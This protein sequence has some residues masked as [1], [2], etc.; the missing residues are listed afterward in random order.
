MSLRLS[1][2]E[3][4]VNGAEADLRAWPVL[5]GWRLL[6]CA[7]LLNAG[8]A[9][10]L[11][12]GFARLAADAAPGVAGVR[13][14]EMTA[15]RVAA[16]ARETG[17]AEEA[18]R[19]AGEWAAALEQALA[20]VSARRGVALLPARSVAAGAADLTAEVEAELARILAAAEAGP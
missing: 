17:G 16:A 9:A 11:A 6:A 18:A 1:Q 13:L 3:A 12:A 2:T 19:A 5:S 7:A 15:G 10:V 4:P 8:V 14:A 20:A